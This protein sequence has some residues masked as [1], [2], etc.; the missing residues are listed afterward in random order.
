MIWLDASE[1]RIKQS[2]QQALHV[3][4][5]RAALQARLE[6]RRAK[7]AGQRAASKGGDDDDLEEIVIVNEGDDLSGG[8]NASKHVTPTSAEHSTAAGAAA[9]ILVKQVQA[10]GVDSL[11]WVTR[12]LE[13]GDSSIRAGQSSDGVSAFGESVKLLEF[14]K[15]MSDNHNNSA[16]FEDGMQSGTAAAHGEPFSNARSSTT[17]SLPWDNFSEY[18]VE[19]P[20]LLLL[21]SREIKRECRCTMILR[22]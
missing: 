6:R 5:R 1:N 8:T 11:V 20:L 2:E 18:T 9:S 22:L 13:F 16:R 10:V 3:M 19:L 14:V 12:L 15:T 21:K 4:E 17:T 7:A